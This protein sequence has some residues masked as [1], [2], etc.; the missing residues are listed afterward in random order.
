MSDLRKDVAHA[1]T[2]HDLSTE[3]LFESAVDQ[4]YAFAYGDPLGIAIWRL[5]WIYDRSTFETAID[6]LAD[7]IEVRKA[8]A[9]GMRKRVA[10]V[11]IEEHL[12]DLCSV[13][14]GRDHIV[15]D[16][17][18]VS[19]ECGACNGSGHRRP[20]AEERMLHA[21]MRP[22]LYRK[23]ERLFTLAHQQID[24]ACADTKAEMLA[25]LDRRGAPRAE[26]RNILAGINTRRYS[27]QVAPPPQI[28]STTA[29]DGARAMPA[30]IKS[31]KPAAAGPMEVRTPRAPSRLS[32]TQEPP[33]GGPA[34]R[35]P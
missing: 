1:I 10:Q 11:A 17:M 35:A 19:S 8:G 25:H 5:K 23:F 2:G 28:K 18:R 22:E 9:Q 13:C 4:I 12:N 27:L 15:A 32:T 21:Q 16:S 20:D 31:I 34:R 3:E 7:R 33:P 29:D 14:G 26:A 30:Q 6:L 24:A